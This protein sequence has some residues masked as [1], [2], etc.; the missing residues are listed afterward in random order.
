MKTFLFLIATLLIFLIGGCEKDTFHDTGRANGIH[1]CTLLEFLQQDNANFDSTVLMI[2]RAGLSS[3]FQGTNPQYPEIT[4]FA[5]TNISI[6]RFLQNTTDNDENILYHSIADI[7]EN[8]CK[9]IILSYVIS[10]KYMKE[11]F[12][13]EEKGTLNGGT[14]KLTLSGLELR[15]YR[16]KG[17][18][19]GVPDIGAIGMGIHFVKSGYIATIAVANHVT[20]NGIVH[21]LDYTFQ[22]ADPVKVSLEN[23]VLIT[24]Q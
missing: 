10:G 6:I 11:D 7:P 14:I 18:F 3:L 1:D 13:F 4:F 9:E 23:T 2:D 20:D 21:P 22:L 15:I 19:M 5:P 12:N 17:S 16:T 24:K 8:V